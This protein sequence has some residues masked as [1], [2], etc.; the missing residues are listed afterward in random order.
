MMYAKIRPISECGSPEKITY[1]PKVSDTGRVTLVAT[2]KVNIYKEIQSHKDSVDLKTLIAR[3]ESGETGV[4]AA[5]HGFYADI[6]EFPQNYL[7]MH[8]VMTD[9][10]NAFDNLP[11]DV[12]KQYNYDFGVYLS[13]MSK[14]V[15]K[16]AS[17]AAE[18]SKSIE[19]EV[20][21]DE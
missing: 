11:V 19:S 21:L 15:S 7:E 6:S 16:A 5:K 20:K 9:I 10:R 2:G 1:S 3:F 13:S 14:P 17:Q 18:P 8:Q 12:R 4:F